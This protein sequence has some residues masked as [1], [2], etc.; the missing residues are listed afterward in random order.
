MGILNGYGSYMLLAT[1]LKLSTSD[2][3]NGPDRI[4]RMK[5]L[6]DHALYVS[7]I[8]TNRRF[9]FIELYTDREHG[10]PGRKLVKVELYLPIHQVM[11]TF[12]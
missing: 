12:A 5:I 7:M 8:G 1:F 4:V 9:F 6:V 10:L 11:H 2:P 3:L